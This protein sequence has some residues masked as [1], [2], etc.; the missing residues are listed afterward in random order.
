MYNFSHFLSNTLIHS[1]LHIYG[2]S[3]KSIKIRKM[4]TFVIPF[5]FFAVFQI[6]VNNKLVRDQLI[7]GWIASR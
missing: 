4:L 2:M 5:A 3:Y 7:D 1:K 6:F